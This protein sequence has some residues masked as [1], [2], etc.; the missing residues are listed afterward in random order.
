MPYDID[1]KVLRHWCRIHDEVNGIIIFMC[2]FHED[3]LVN[4]DIWMIN[5]AF[6]SAPKGYNQI[7]NTMGGN[8]LKI[9]FLLQHIYQ[10]LKRK[11]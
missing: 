1:P 7:L 11:K 9:L 10:W 8:T 5:G 6:R 4:S 2:D 3:Y